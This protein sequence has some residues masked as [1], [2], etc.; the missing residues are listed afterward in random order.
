MEAQTSGLGGQGLLS[1]FG[2]P[3]PLSVPGF[4]LV[5]LWVTLRALI[6]LQLFVAAASMA[7]QGPLK[8]NLH[9]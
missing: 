8:M 3:Q 7:V 6:S 2:P 5:S 9:L 1:G 4:L